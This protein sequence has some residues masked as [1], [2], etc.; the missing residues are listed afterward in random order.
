LENLKLQKEAEEKASQERERERESEREQQ[1]KKERE[2]QEKGKQEVKKTQ[3]DDED[4]DDEKEAARM[5]KMF[6]IAPTKLS[7]A[8]PEP[9]RTG[10]DVLLQKERQH[11]P[12]LK[13]VVE[14]PKAAVEPPKAVI[15]PTKPV[16]KETKDWREQDKEFLNNSVSEEA[17]EDLEAKEAARMAKMFGLSPQR[18]TTESPKNQKT[19][20]STQAS[21]VSVNEDDA[22]AAKEA[23]RM[24]RMMGGNPKNYDPREEA[25]EK[26]RKKFEQSLQG[27]SDPKELSKAF[28]NDP[29]M[30]SHLKDVKGVIAVNTLKGV[31]VPGG[32]KF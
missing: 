19:K 20:S 14:P 16:E 3:V 10:V 12:I 30:M 25:K 21:D 2:E 5:S 32:H 27:I 15:E 26:E 29:E 8:A 24:A 18:L 6:G 4:D 13:S 1:A 23:E 22:S 11:D 31:N 7:K 28:L 9:H 17:D